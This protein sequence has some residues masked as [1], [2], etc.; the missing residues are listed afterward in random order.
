MEDDPTPYDG[1][2]TTGFVSPAGDA[3]EDAA[4]FA[5]AAGA[6]ATTRPGAVPSLPRRAEIGAAGFHKI[7]E[8]ER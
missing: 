8:I 4:R 2:N 5:A 7:P 1:G 3:L 6:L